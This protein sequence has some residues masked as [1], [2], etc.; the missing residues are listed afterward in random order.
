MN[1]HFR[2]THMFLHLQAR[3]C[4]E[5]DAVLGVDGEPTYDNMSAASMPYMNGVVYETLRLH[6]PVPY[7][8]KICLHEVRFNMGYLR[9][10]CI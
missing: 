9:E 10:S 5:V 7:D 8:A 4:E 6:P 2:Y 3:L 1:T